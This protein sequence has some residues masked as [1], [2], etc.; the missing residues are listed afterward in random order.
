PSPLQWS[1]MVLMAAAMA[2]IAAG[3]VTDDLPDLPMSRAIYRRCRSAP[4]MARLPSGGLP[5]ATPVSSL[6]VYGGYEAAQ[7][8]TN[9]PWCEFDPW[10]VVGT[11][12]ERPSR[13]EAEASRTTVNIWQF[14][15]LR[16]WL[17][18]DPRSER[19]SCKA[20]KNA[21]IKE[22]GAWLAV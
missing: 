11:R 3:F 7:S 9:G 13:A 22:L 18:S 4:V 17:S 2:G 10:P 20:R 21:P 12:G 16:I 15:S 19:A 14:Q 5:M 1:A 6:T 8:H